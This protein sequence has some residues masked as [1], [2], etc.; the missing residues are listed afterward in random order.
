LDGAIDLLAWKIWAREFRPNLSSRSNWPDRNILSDPIAEA[1]VFC[2]QQ[3]FEL[4]KH[5]ASLLLDDEFGTLPGLRSVASQ[6][7]RATPPNDLPKARRDIGRDFLVVCC[8]EIAWDEG[9]WFDLE[10]SELTGEPSNRKSGRINS[11]AL[12]QPE[13]RPS[14]AAL[15]LYELL[16]SNRRLALLED[17]VPSPEAIRRI[18]A[19]RETIKVAVRDR[20]HRP[21]ENW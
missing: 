6:L 18:W 21:D 19:E 9:L 14:M 20:L 16:A 13:L 17:K 15:R 12:L 5:H 10:K 2:D 3:F 7:L 4:A 8:I 1:L 11:A